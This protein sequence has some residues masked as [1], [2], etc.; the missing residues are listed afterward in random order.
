MCVCV[1]VCVGGGVSVT[2]LKV[3]PV[4]LVFGVCYPSATT[5]S[6]SRWAE[7]RPRGNGEEEV[8]LIGHLVT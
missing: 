5:G 2:W 8:V 1:C 3:N 6:I 7:P 4:T